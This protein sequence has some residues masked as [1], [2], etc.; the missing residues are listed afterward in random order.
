MNLQDYSSY[1]TLGVV[2]VVSLS[3]VA[4]FLIHFLRSQRKDRYI[5]VVREK[6]EGAHERAMSVILDVEQQAMKDTGRDKKRAFDLI[7]W[8]AMKRDLKRAGLP[9]RPE[10]LILASA[11]LAFAIGFV[12]LNIPLYPVWM[13]GASLIP[14]CFLLVRKSILGMFMEGRKLK[15]MQQLILFI[16]TTQRSVSVGTAP[17]EAVVE[18]MREATSPLVENLTAIKELLDLG[19]DF[20]DAINLAADKI[21]LAEFDIFAASL[22]AQSRAG[23]SIGNV[24]KDV[25]ES[26]RARMELQRKIATMTGEG[27]FNALLLGGLPISLVMY[28]RYTQEDLYAEVWNAGLTGALT[29][30]GTIAASVF[31]AWLAMRIARV[32]V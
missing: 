31:G 20:I 9:Q 15:M 1:I 6:T 2:L 26:A 8:M 23:G 13:Q 30:I 18:A 16:E 29:Y 14:V 17:D 24:L 25:V 21:N 11:G 27:R 22:S 32:S 5:K 28:L 12:I 3:A 10:I 19:Y 4:F 7:N